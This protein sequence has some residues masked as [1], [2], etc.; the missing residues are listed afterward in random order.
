MTPDHISQS[1]IQ[2]IGE[3][4]TRYTPPAGIMELR[5]AI[6]LETSRTRNCPV[7]PEQVI[8]APGAKPLLF[9]PMMALLEPGDEVILPGPCFPSYQACVRLFGAKP[10]TVPL[11]EEDD[12]SMSIDA[13]EASLT[14]RTRMIILNS[15]SN[16]TGGMISSEDLHRIAALARKF[17]FWILSDEIYSRLVF[18]SDSPDSICS[19]PRMGERSI[20]VDGF[21]KTFSMTGWRLGYGVMPA[22][23]AEKVSLLLTHSVGCTAH[24]TQWAG[25][26]AITGSQVDVDTAR[27]T[28]RQ[29]RD[30]LVEALNN[31]PGI[32][33]RYPRGAFYAFPR[34]SSFGLTSHEMADYLLEQAGVAVLPGTS[35]GPEGEGFLRLSFA[36]STKNLLRAVERIGSALSR[37]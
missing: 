34:I 6:A 4:R 1:G 18:D 33:C 20:L 12:F 27:Q 11:V 5:E 14:S 7:C 2:A 30:I 22:W 24:F 26:T 28:Y 10:V 21:S 9:F 17:D 36:N 15:P 35:F 13:L 23:L 29:R 37:L 25:L 32:S 19:L 3:G 31:V 8:V 16:P